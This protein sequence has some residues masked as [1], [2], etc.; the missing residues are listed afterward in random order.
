MYAPQIEALRGRYRC[1][2]YDHRGQGRSTP[3]SGRCISIETNYRDAVALIEQLGLGACHF[4]GLSMGGFV[5]M[6]LAARRPDLIRSL[7]LIATAADAEPRANVPKYRMLNAV[8]RAG[9]LALVAPRVMPIM[10][11]ETFLNDES[12]AAER[13]LRSRQLSSN[14]RA[15]FRAVNGVIERAAV[16]AELHRI[17]AP[18][19]VLRGA[20]DAAI[21]R[22]RGRALADGIRGARFVELPTGGHTLTLE[23]PAAVTRELARFLDEHR[24]APAGAQASDRSLRTNTRA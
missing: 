13:Q 7:V 8:A 20:E 9:G 19:L 22:D 12:R 6:R 1:I 14:R 23:E 24:G 17:G 21:V 18:T 11:G 3:G 4:V 10:F 5:G 2:A 16:E 15:V